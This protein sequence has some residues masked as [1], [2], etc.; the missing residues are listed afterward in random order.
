MQPEI[1]IRN[2]AGNDLRVL[3]KRL[4]RP[5]PALNQ[6]TSFHPWEAKA[7]PDSKP[8]R[9]FGVNSFPSTAAGRENIMLYMEADA[10]MHTATYV[11]CPRPPR[12]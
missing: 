11:S 3:A 7:D 2:E 12:N 4:N 9:M 8:D 1:C 6:R 10:P 5:D